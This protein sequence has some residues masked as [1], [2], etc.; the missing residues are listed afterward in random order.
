MSWSVVV[1][2][3]R[4]TG[5][6]CR[7]PAFPV[8]GRGGRLFRGLVLDPKFCIMALVRTDGKYERLVTVR[9]R[10]WQSCVPWSV[11][12]SRVLYNGHGKEPM[13]TRASGHRPSAEV[14]VAGTT[15][16]R[17]FFGLV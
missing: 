16:C 7:R 17:W 3:V 1:G 15:A 2:S 13:A 8:I 12:V 6:T 9:Q 5:G 11:E 4:G 14:A 10:M